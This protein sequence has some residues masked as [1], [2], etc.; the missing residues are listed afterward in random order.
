ME[1]FPPRREEVQDQIR[2]RQCPEG[3]RID[4]EP[5]RSYLLS[6]RSPCRGRILCP[7][8]TWI[9]RCQ[10]LRRIVARMV[11]S[12]ESSSGEMRLLTLGNWSLLASKF[13]HQIL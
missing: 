4:Q 9:W 2:A 8:V 3:E 10:E 7:S 13:R 12:K 5:T 1:L 11:C 6:S